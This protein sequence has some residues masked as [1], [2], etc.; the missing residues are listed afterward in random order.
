[1]P[2]I[3]VILVNLLIIFNLLIRNL[4]DQFNLMMP[5]TCSL[6]CRTRLP[7]PANLTQLHWLTMS[8]SNKSSQRINHNLWLKS[9]C[10]IIT[11]WRITMK[12]CNNKSTLINKLGLKLRL[13]RTASHLQLSTSR[14][15]TTMTMM[16]MNSQWVNSQLQILSEK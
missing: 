1:M 14:K 3:L 16:M 8:L 13:T 11:T 7:N 6:T 5:Q 9:Q 15:K 10:Q 12:C 4:K 2:R